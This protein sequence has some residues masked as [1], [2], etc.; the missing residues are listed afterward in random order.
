[1]ERSALV[2]L[3]SA[4]GEEQEVMIGSSTPA[5]AIGVG[6]GNFRILLPKGSAVAVGDP[7]VFPSISPRIFGKVEEIES[8]ASDTFERV[9]FQ[10]PVNLFELRWIEI[11]QP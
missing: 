6:G 7:I 4:P 11:L 5:K 1:Y 10:S 3:L 9:Y 2:K 8:D